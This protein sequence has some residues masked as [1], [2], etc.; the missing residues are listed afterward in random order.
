MRFLHSHLHVLPTNHRDISDEQ[1]ERF[2][3]D[4]ST[5]QTCLSGETGSNCGGSLKDKLRIRIRGNWVEKI[6]NTLDVSVNFPFILHYVKLNKSVHYFV[7]FSYPWCLILPW[8]QV[9]KH[10]LME[11]LQLLCNFTANKITWI[12][13]QWKF[14]CWFLE[15]PRCYGSFVTT[16]GISGSK[17]VKGTSTI[18]KKL[19]F[20]L[21]SAI[22]YK[23]T[24]AHHYVAFRR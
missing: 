17:S 6:L 20:F 4:I 7:G 18:V 9:Q 5:M 24:S 21:F 16:F 8:I 13:I 19:I 1:C 10:L 12:H 11:I 22:R 23:S 3:Y 14:T 15:N 2:R